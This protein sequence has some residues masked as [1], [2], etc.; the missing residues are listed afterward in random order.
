MN[1]IFFFFFFEIL[2]MIPIDSTRFFFFFFPISLS[3]AWRRGAIW[4]FYIYIYICV[5]VCFFI[6]LLN[7]CDFLLIRHSSKFRKITFF[8][9]WFF[10]FQPNKRNLYLFSI[11][12]L[13]HHLYKNTQGEKHKHLLSSQPIRTFGITTEQGG[14][15]S[16]MPL[17]QLCTLKK[18]T[19]SKSGLVRLKL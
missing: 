11:I 1:S 7:I 3:F 17:S 18:P 13:F 5:C 8:I 10:F 6:F 9:L 12:L 14:V 2:L 16:W 15:G 4:W 19:Q